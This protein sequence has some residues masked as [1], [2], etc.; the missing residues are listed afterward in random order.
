MFSKDTT[1][2]GLI[3]DNDQ[4]QREIIQHFTIMF[5]TPADNFLGIY[6]LAWPGPW[7]QL[8]SVRRLNKDSSS[9]CWNVLDSLHCSWPKYNRDVA[10]CLSSVEWQLYI[11]RQGGE[12]GGSPVPDLELVHAGRVEKKAQSIAGKWSVCAASLCKNGY[13]NIKP[14]S[15]RLKNS[16]FPRAIPSIS[17]L[18]PS[19]IMCNK[20]LSR[21]LDCSLSPIFTVP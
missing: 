17:P 6:N 14:R 11:T 20:S 16:F 12:K 10:L 21:V 2:V 13:R 18:H 5:R 1:I 19:Y 9:G 3:L 15:T 7:I 4:P 8:I